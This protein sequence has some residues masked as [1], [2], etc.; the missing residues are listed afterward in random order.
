MTLAGNIQ[1]ASPGA[2]LTA[3]RTLTANN[4]VGQ[5]GTVSLY[6]V[7][8]N[9]QSVTDKLVIDGGQATGI[10]YL[11]IQNAGGLG[12]K[13]TGEGIN[14]VQTKNG[15]TT[16]ADAFELANAGGK[17]IA[18][19]YEYQL[20]RSGEDW[21]LCSTLIDG[22]PRYSS[23]TSLY[24]AKVA[25][26][27]LYSE[28]TLGTLHERIGDI[29][30]IKP[31]RG[32]LAWGRVI[33]QQ[34]HNDGASDGIYGNSIGSE[35]D[36]SAFQEGMDFYVS[37]QGAER[38]SMG[39]FLTLGQGRADVKHV[40]SD[41]KVVDAGS[42]SFMAYGLGGYL[43]YLNGK[44]GYLDGV[45]QANFFDQS[46]S[47]LEISSDSNKGLS[48]LA[49]VEVGHR[50]GLGGD[51]SGWHIEPQAQFN[52]QT[53]NQSDTKAASNAGTEST[54]SFATSTTLTS[55]IGAR[56]SKTWLNGDEQ[57]GSLWITPSV[58]HTSGADSKTCFSTP[59]QGSVAFRDQLMG[60]RASLQIGM[61]GYVTENVSVNARVGGEI[62]LTDDSQSSY[63][64]Q[65]G[66]KVVF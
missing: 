13:T 65:V 5:G 18:G 24:S 43:T 35:G 25:Q 4:W 44:G 23:T 66:V 64:G 50:F 11:N 29:E 37:V 46:S 57:P 30:A 27:L 40:T 59:S 48:T 53:F 16:T 45:L 42:N 8:G 1:F 55:R 32:A 15:A 39:G 9:S 20:A 63:G 60:T 21:F 61:D 2:T 38:N 36:L 41:G 6:T 58:I 62:S 47:P 17:V 33:G 3:G 49:S 28:K 22:R 26:A 12:D 19:A 56:L 52:V 10:T 7:L 31:N 14:L 54:V 51:I 34:H